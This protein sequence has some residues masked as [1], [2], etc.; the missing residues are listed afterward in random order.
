MFIEIPHVKSD[1]GFLGFL[2]NSDNSVRFQIARVYFLSS[3]PQNAVRGSHGHLELEQILIPVVG[4]FDL[5]VINAEGEVSIHMNDPSKG[6]YIGKKSWR[7]LRNFSK[8]S[9]CLVLASQ[10][11]NPKDY[12]F[13]LDHFLTLIKTEKNDS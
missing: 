5:K 4:S 8:D 13:D 1:I 6:Y 2:Q 9:C 11:Y 7:E 10:E 3:V 12:F